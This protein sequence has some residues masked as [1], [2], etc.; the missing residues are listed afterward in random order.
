[1]KDIKE[2]NIKFSNPLS[3]F[4]EMMEGPLGYMEGRVL[5]K[6]RKKKKDIN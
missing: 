3:M 2:G 6:K 1:M 5:V 4:E